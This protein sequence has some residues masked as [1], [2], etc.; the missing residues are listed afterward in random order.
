MKNEER[1]GL[2]FIKA[3]LFEIM[4]NA[5]IYFKVFHGTQE[6]YFAVSSEE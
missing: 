1:N 4:S 3:F 2:A 5:G 6:C